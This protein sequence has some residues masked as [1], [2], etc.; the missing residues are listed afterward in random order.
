MLAVPMLNCP[1]SVPEAAPAVSAP[2]VEPVF[3]AP[4]PCPAFWQPAV[5]SPT[6]NTAER[7]F[8]ILLF[9]S[10]PAFS[11]VCFSHAKA[12]PSFFY[13]IYYI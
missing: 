3:A 1:D 2:A 10:F 8:F 5:I 6:A 12:L 13:I 7:S 9:I 11:L 4:P